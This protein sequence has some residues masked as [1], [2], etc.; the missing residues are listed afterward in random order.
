MKK[1]FVLFLLFVVGVFMTYSSE[2]YSLAFYV[3]LVC[4]S[5]LSL[6]SIF[7]FLNE[8][9]GNFENSDSSPATNVLRLIM[10]LF[11]LCVH[12]FSH[13]T[14]SGMYFKINVSIICAFLIF[15]IIRLV[16]LVLKD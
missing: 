13:R 4:I 10:Y 3:G 9:T 11:S 16:V 1:Q 7:M 5:V 8:I 12:G 6:Y 15:L 14:I 2:F